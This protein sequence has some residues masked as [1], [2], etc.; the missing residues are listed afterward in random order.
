MTDWSQAEVEATITDYLTMLSAEL[1][2]EPYNKT[3]HRRALSR[4]LQGRSDSAIE[5]KHQNI[6]AILIE[7][8]LP[9]IP[10]YKPLR[11]YQRLLG[12]AVSQRV[13]ADTSFLRAVEEDVTREAST[14]DL[15]SAEDILAARDDPPVPRE[16]EGYPARRLRERSRGLIQTDYLELEARN[17]SLGA[18]GEEFALRYERARLLMAGKGFLADRI[19][20]VSMTAG[21]WIGF[22]IK[23]YE[24]DGRDRLIEVKT[25]AYGKEVPFYLS[26]N[27]VEVSRER[28]QAYHL[29]RVFMFRKQPK[30]YAIQGALD[31]KCRLEPVTFLGEMA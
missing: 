27:E 29:Y 3:E 25:T 16:R 30:L 20:Q 12:E 15:P 23:S 5:R 2:G 8:G 17:R 11:N 4:L 10:G 21:G 9:Y 18:A 28:R 24:V 13:T 22:D 7:I 6:S 31:E 26:R 1:K 14:A 19:E